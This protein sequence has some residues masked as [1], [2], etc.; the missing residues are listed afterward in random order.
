[1]APQPAPSKVSVKTAPD[2]RIY[3]TSLSAGVGEV[4]G[5]RRPGRPSPPES[6]LPTKLKKYMSHDNQKSRPRGSPP[7]AV[8]VPHVEPLGGK[9][10]YQDVI[11]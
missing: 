2:I 3:V 8:A 4:P 1:V 7:A 11:L 10:V 5:A 6:H 9:R